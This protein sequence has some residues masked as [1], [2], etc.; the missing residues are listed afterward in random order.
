MLPSK[1]NTVVVRI[2]SPIARYTDL[3]LTCDRQLSVRGLKGLIEAGLPAHPPPADQKLVYA[4]KLLVDELLLEQFLRFEDDCSV[5]TIHLVCR[6]PEQPAKAASQPVS[7]SQDSDVNN[8]LRH[9]G[10]NSSDQSAVSPSNAAN[11]VTAAATDSEPLTSAG[12]IDA[13]TRELRRIQE[14]LQSLAATPS[15]GGVGVEDLA[16]MEEY[17]RQYL[18]LYSQHMLRLQQA[19]HQQQADHQ[20]MPQPERAGPGAVAANEEADNI[21]NNNNDLLDRIYAITR[22]MLLFSV[23]YFHSSFFRLLFVAVIAFLAHRFQNNQNNN[24]NINNNN[25]NNN[26]A[27]NNEA[28]NPRGEEQIAAADVLP[29]DDGG[30]RTSVESEVVGEQEEE[31]PHLLVVAVNFVTSFLSSIIPGNNPPL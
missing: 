18:Q 12:F 20:L 15:T 4:G 6:I 21:N 2:K 26:R 28:H 10:S 16:S 30:D 31:K 11:L 19:S 17:Y 1:N 14:L 25:N 8:G 22:I 7:T 29:N 24:Q 5:F 3:M 13:E 23:I 9:R 27:R